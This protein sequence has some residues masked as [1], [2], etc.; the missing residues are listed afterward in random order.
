VLCSRSLL[1]LAWS[2]HASF[3]TNASTLH[4]SLVSK[5]DATPKTFQRPP[6]A[7]AVAVAGGGGGGRG[8]GGGPPPP[9]ASSSADATAGAGKPKAKVARV[10]HERACTEIEARHAKCQK[11][12]TNRPIYE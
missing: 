8:G 11:R 4:V 10:L 5:W 1:T 7:V 6:A 9:P 2:A 3:D 12:P